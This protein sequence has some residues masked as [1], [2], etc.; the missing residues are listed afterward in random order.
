MMDASRKSGWPF[1]P[2][3]R[4]VIVFVGPLVAAIGLLVAHPKGLYPEA[5]GVVLFSFLLTGFAR[6]SRLSL[7][8]D[9]VGKGPSLSYDHVFLGML[10]LLIVDAEFIR[11]WID[12]RD[13]AMCAYEAEGDKPWLHHFAQF[14]AV[15]VG[16][17]VVFLLLIVLCRLLPVTTGTDSTS[18]PDPVGRSGTA[19]P[20]TRQGVDLL[21]DV[22]TL[23]WTLQLAASAATYP[24]L[25]HLFR[26]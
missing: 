11:L 6:Y 21:C 8:N 20:L 24:Y 1:A 25:C 5:A 13:A 14:L 2:F 15:G 17:L 22:V 12:T 3:A 19:V 18:A 7:R 4:A 23:V 10:G 9:S 26:Q 16:I